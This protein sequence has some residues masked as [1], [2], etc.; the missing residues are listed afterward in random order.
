MR[1][2]PGEPIRVGQRHILLLLGLE[3]L[4]ADLSLSAGLLSFG[5]ESLA[6]S[7]HVCLQS[8]PVDELFPTSGLHRQDALGLLQSDCSGTGVLAPLQLLR[9]STVLQL[10]GTSLSPIPPDDAIAACACDCEH[11]V[12]LRAYDAQ[13]NAEAEGGTE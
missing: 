10:P 2:H 11:L 13:E 6:V 7:L 9:H 12:M 1:F 8:S 5:R 3:I 4:Q